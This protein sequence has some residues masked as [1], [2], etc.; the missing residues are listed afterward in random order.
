MSMTTKAPL[1]WLQAKPAKVEAIE[2]FLRS[3][4][5]LVDQEPTTKPWLAA[6]FGPTSFG[7]FDARWAP[8][9][10]WQRRWG[11]A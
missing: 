2:E 1:V 10:A 6:R 8:S 11:W 3:A 7:I 5:L 9:E 4:L